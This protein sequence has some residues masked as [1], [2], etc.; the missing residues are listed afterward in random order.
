VEAD[1]VVQ[2]VRRILW[3]FRDVDV[4]PIIIVTTKVNYGDRPAA[5][6]AIAAIRETAENLG[7]G[8][9]KLHGS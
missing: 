9:R 3:R 1:T 4:D 8:E 5:C 2:H 7:K 6:I